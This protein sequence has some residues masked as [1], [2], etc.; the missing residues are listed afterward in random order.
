[1][2]R[3]KFATALLLLTLILSGVPL[4][5]QQQPKKDPNDPVEKIRDEGMNC[6]QVMQTLS[7]L[8]DVIS[9]R[10]TGSPD[11]KRASSVVFRGMI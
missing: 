4:Q 1:M 6:S 8:T 2:S 10:L 5:A 7:Y 11:L 9:P 3:R